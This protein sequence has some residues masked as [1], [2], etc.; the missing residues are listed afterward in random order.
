MST[1]PDLVDVAAAAAYVARLTGRPC[2]KS[3]IRSWAH[4]GHIARH[5]KRGRN[6]QYDLAELHKHVTGHDPYEPEVDN[7]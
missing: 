3:T 7:P 5:G 2:A 6:T 4:R 1:N